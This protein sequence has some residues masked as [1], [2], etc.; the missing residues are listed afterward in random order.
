M[1]ISDVYIRY[2]QCGDEWLIASTMLDSSLIAP[3]LFS[4]GYALELYLK[5]ALIKLTQ[6][7]KRVIKYSHSLKGLI[8]D[9]F[10]QD[11]NFCPT[12][13]IDN[14]AYDCDFLNFKNLSKLPQKSNLEYVH[15]Q[16]LYIVVKYLADVKYLGTTLK[17]HKGS[18]SFGAVEENPLWIKIFSEIRNYI[19]API[20]YGNIL[21]DFISEKNCSK[22]IDKYLNQ[23]LA[24]NKPSN[25]REK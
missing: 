12:L 6:D 8:D 19:A 13:K 16:E 4:I 1:S 14:E 2:F 21:K 17:G 9:C 5:S 10:G 22:K 7:E 15:K 23:I 24:I 11:S 25:N 20:S 3:K 18:Y